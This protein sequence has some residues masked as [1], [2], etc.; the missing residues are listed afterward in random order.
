MNKE[1]QIVG[2]RVGRETFGLPIS[3][4]RE[5]VRVPEITSVPN[6][7]SYI[8]GVINLRGRIIPVVDLRKRFGEKVPEPSKKNRIVVAE[9]EGRMIGLLVNSASEVLRIAPSQIEPPNN[10]FREGE[11][12]YITGVGKLNGR[13]VILLE[14]SRVLQ[15]GELGQLQEAAENAAVPA[16]VTAREF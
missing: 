8:E 16:G 5:I 9:V 15:Q 12:D 13:L 2:L 11:L 6:A 4:V 7:P 10:V 14:L 1:Q 3:I